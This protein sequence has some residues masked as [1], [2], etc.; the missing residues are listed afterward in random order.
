MIDHDLLLTFINVGDQSF[1]IFL[2]IK[3][4]IIYWLVGKKL[5]IFRFDH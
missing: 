1:N 5:L 2:Y 3:H 4:N